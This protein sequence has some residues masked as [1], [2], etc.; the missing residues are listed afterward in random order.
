MSKSAK[1]VFAFGAY[2]VVAGPGFLFVPNLVLGT[3]GMPATNEVWIRVLGI[4][5]TILGIYYIA[6]ARSGA[7]L[8]FKVSVWV[9]TAF[10]GATIVLVAL[11]LAPLPIVG[12]GIADALGALWTGLAL[13]GDSR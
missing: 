12:F 4:V 10:L 2:L 3:L 13:R 8:Y 11:G 5:V 7:T 6:A 1:S 9:R